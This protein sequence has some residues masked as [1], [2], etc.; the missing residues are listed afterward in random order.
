MKD[1]ALPEHILVV[2]KKGLIGQ[3]LVKTLIKDS[4]VVY[5]SEVFSIF[6]EDNLSALQFINYRKRFPEIPYISYSKIIVI[7]NGE[8]EIKDV[9]KE[10]IKAA[11]EVKARII[12]VIPLSLYDKKFSQEIVDFY[13]RAFVVVFGEIFSAF[14][15]FNPLTPAIYKK[16]HVAQFLEQ[17][18]E[19]KRIIVPNVIEEKTYSVCLE[20]VVLGIKDIAFVSHSSSRIFCLFPKYPLTLFSLALLMQ[21]IEPDLRLD[22]DYS[23]NN[24]EKKNIIKMPERAE[25]VDTSYTLQKRLREVLSDILTKKTSKKA[26][27]EKNHWHSPLKTGVVFIVITFFVPFFLT[28][29]LVFLG[30]FSLNSSK[31]ELER[32]DFSKALESAYTSNRLLKWADGF[33]Q[34]ILIKPAFIPEVI[35]K[36]KELSSVNISLSSSLQYFLQLF[37]TEKPTNESDF[38]YASS[39]LIHSIALLQQFKVDNQSDIKRFMPKSFFNSDSFDLLRSLPTNILNV[40]PPLFG[41]GGGKKYLILF[42]NNMELRPGGGFIGS[43]GLLTFKKG[44]IVDFSIHNVYDAD[45]KLKGHIEPPYP[46]RRY[47]P[48]VHLYL[49]DSNFDVDFTKN[50]SRAAFF[51]KAETGETVDGVI[52]IDV[53][54]IKEIL[55]VIGPVYIPEYKETVTADNVYRLT[56][57]YA[58]KKFFPGSTQ[59]KDFLKALFDSISLTLI[60]KKDDSSNHK[61][62]YLRLIKAVINSIAE[63]HTL[64]SFSDPRVQNL[65]TFYNMSSSLFDSRENNINT[66]NDYLGINEANIGI[67]KVNNFIKRKIDQSMSI[68]NDGEV[69]GEVKIT[70]KN[71]STPKDWLG[72]DYKN[73]LRVILPLDS[74][75]S[76]ININGKEQVLTSAITD[77]LIYEAKGFT[78]S[79]GLEVETVEQE[80]KTIFGFL[81]IVKRGE[82][83]TITV[84]YTIPQKISVEK[85][86]F[87]YDLLYFKQPGTDEYPFSF[88]LSYPKSFKTV[89]LSEGLID[90]KN[91]ISL[92][93]KLLKDIS[94]NINFSKQ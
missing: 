41:F 10:L 3:E 79:E 20:D 89:R 8:D 50:A 66:V 78:A 77:F 81:V 70:Y 45:G 90:A 11:E 67:N 61:G 31:N 93:T 86:S 40:A 48:L 91:K 5:V 49:R 39:S 94:L 53:S 75:I 76:S 68:S 4:K 47:L 17:A 33:S 1:T 29:L 35:A 26:K 9:W 13:N 6:I 43:Y 2:D 62:L 7:Y 44:K 73:Y 84:R 56:Q 21:K 32:G 80:G 88:T 59:K 55:K 27:K 24:K 74:Q 69:L 19:N 37:T 57:E 16:T 42:Q 38:Q 18:Y 14:S 64:F 54:F 72:G 65:F 15:F 25:F 23:K 85:T 12:F 36:G 71:L 52:G 58:E 51:L 60:L 34:I 82:L 30:V 92:E 22:F 83:K 63:K 46:I 28:F 87:T